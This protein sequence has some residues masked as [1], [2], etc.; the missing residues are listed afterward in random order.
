MSELSL[1]LPRT[2]VNKIPGVGD[3]PPSECPIEL[4]A[5]HDEIIS[6]LGNLLGD[7]DVEVLADYIVVLLLSPA[8]TCDILRDE[9]QEFLGDSVC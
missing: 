7:V 4:K 2:L 8:M 9:L 5:F 1:P 3:E 6:M